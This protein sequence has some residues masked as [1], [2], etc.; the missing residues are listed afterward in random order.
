MLWETMLG[1]NRYRSVMF[2]PDGTWEFLKFEPPTSDLHATH[3]LVLVKEIWGDKYLTRYPFGRF[4]TTFF[5]KIER[6]VNEIGKVF[7]DD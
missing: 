4:I 1:Y 3:P 6:E 7:E 2:R 5:D